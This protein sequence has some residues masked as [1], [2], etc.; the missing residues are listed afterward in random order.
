MAQQD[1]SSIHG[2]SLTPAP[3]PDSARACCCPPQRSLPAKLW[4]RLLDPLGLR[5]GPYAGN[6][7]RTSK[8]TL[9][10]FLPLNL[11]EQFKRVANLYFAF[12]IALQAGGWRCPGWAAG[13]AAPL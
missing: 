12:M 13:S 5:K 3:P 4:G 8:Y 11:F 1:S 2:L 10:T 6:A 7:I 9:L